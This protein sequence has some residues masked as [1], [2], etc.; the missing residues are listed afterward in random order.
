MARI[1]LTDRFNITSLFYKLP[2]FLLLCLVCSG[3]LAAWLITRQMIQL[4]YTQTQVMFESDA[5]NLSLFLKQ[6]QNRL[7][8]AATPAGEQYGQGR[9]CHEVQLCLVVPCH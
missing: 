8:D 5:R 9:L 4:V 6:E 2:G 1:R 7:H 3:A